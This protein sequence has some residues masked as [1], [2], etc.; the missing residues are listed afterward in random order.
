MFV[1]IKEDKKISI[2]DAV[3]GNTYFCP[4]CQQPLIIRE[5]KVRVKH[6]A[7]KK[8]S[9]CDNW[10]D[11]SEWHKAWQERFPIECREV[12]LEKNGVKHRADVCVG[13]TVIE[14]QHSP[15]SYEEF[16]ARNNFYTSCGYNLVWLFDMSN[17]IKD[18]E[19]GW[20]NVLFKRKQGQFDS[21]NGLGG[22]VA[23]YFQ[24]HIENIDNTRFSVGGGDKSYHDWIFIAKE[25]SISHCSYYE[26]CYFIQVENF[27]KQFGAINDSTIMSISDIFNITNQI[28]QKQQVNKTGVFYRPRQYP[29]RRFHF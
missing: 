28:K 20:G 19:Q 14:F 12:V 3:K 10:G 18:E 27:L 25:I 15:I 13:N 26:T 21:F 1:A 4:V 16:V 5:G 22:K 29:R 2:N 24:T 6:F 7:H 8:Q 9:L 17:K 23:I 11:M